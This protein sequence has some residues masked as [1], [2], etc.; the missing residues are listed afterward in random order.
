MQRTYEILFNINF[1]KNKQIRILIYT[2]KII[3]INK[4]L[5]SIIII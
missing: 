4:Y 2:H 1:I 5:L 3:L